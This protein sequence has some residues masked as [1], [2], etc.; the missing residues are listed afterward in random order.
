VP[1]IRWLKHDTRSELMP[2][3][4]SVKHIFKTVVEPHERMNFN[5][6]KL[7]NLLD[8]SIKQ[9]DGWRKLTKEQVAILVTPQVARLPDGA[10][11]K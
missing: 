10:S 3:V 4:G 1:L 9:A 11:L 2:A 6:R 7:A 8:G 5:E